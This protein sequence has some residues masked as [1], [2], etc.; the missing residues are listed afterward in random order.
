MTSTQRLKHLFIKILFGVGSFI[1][2]TIVFA[3]SFELIAN[4]DI[5]LGSSLAQMTIQ[6]SINKAVEEFDPKYNSKTLEGN[7][8]LGPLDSLIIPSLRIFVYLEEARKVEDYWYQRPSIAQYIELNKDS[9][10]NPV[11]YLIYSSR[12]W[13]SIPYVEEIEEGMEVSIVTKQG[14]TANFIVEDRKILPL[15][16]SFIVNK[17]ERRQVI[18][19]IEDTENSR[20]YGYSLITTR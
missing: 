9:Y 7:A 11:D 15:N 18:L 20:Y 6:E 4:K 13:R 16:T 19:M 8:K 14:Y 2:T 3:N 10:G 5:P 17:S 12:S 1:F